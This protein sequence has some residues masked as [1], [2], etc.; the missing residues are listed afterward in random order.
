M[1]KKIIATAFHTGRDY[2]S[3]HG[4]VVCAAAD[5]SIDGVCMAES[6]L[7]EYGLALLLKKIGQ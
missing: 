1:M 6:I 7:N 3:A 4:K 2:Q 5:C